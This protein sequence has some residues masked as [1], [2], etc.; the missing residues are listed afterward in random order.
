MSAT[1]SG[2]LSLQIMLRIITPSPDAHGINHAQI[3]YASEVFREP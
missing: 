2:G 3:P 1:N